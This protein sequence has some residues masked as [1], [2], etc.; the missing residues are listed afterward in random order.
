MSRLPTPLMFVKSSQNPAKKGP[1]A[2][3]NRFRR[4][5]RANGTRPAIL[6]LVVIV[7]FHSLD[8]NAQAALH[9]RLNPLTTLHSPFQFSHRF[10]AAKLEPENS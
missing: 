6:S 9:M 5:K 4:L 1:A 2:D 3:L 10:V 7:N 8:E